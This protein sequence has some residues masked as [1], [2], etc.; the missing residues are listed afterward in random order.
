MK[1]VLASLLLLPLFARA[2]DANPEATCRTHLRNLGGAVK[3]YQLLHDNKTPGKLSD[4]YLDGLIDSYGDFVCPASGTTI[5]MTSEI[6]AKSDYTF[7]SLPDT[8]DL[9]AR[10]KSPHHAND[11][12]L[13]V[14]ADGAIKPVAVPGASPPQQTTTPS[15]SVMRPA[16][17]E[18]P[19]ATTSSETQPG[20]TTEEEQPLPPVIAPQM[21]KP[22][23][24]QPTPPAP[25]LGPRRAFLGVEIGDHPQQPG[26]GAVVAK[27]APGGPADT[28]LKPAD[29]IVAAN[30]EPIETS[31][32]LLEVLAKLSPGARLDLLFYREGKMQK[33]NLILGLRPAELP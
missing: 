6:D 28:V 19:P 26:I 32:Q 10:E 12:V 3:A 17:Q 33:S 8:K 14:F 25:T 9:L 24:P 18:T 23:T 4:L 1:A 29:I 15:T 21:P 2:E 11:T 22:G 20:S 16:V 13:A 31:R 7:E 30:G 27:V 5:T